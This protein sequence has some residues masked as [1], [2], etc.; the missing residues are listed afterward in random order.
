MFSIGQVSKQSGIK[1]PTIRYYE[2]IGLIV[3][4][5]RSVG[6]QRR[7]SNTEINRLA[8][9]KHARELGFDLNTVRSLIELS[10]NRSQNCD[11]IDKLANNHLEQVRAKLVQLM[12]METELERMVRG[13]NKG[14][15][16]ECYVVEPLINHELCKNQHKQ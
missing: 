1:V 14:K 6:N 10:R 4:R 3:P 7:Y 5:S 15:V 11:E 16:E 9:I 12:R 8:F 2:G 13:C